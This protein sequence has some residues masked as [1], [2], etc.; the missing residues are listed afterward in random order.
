MTDNLLAPCDGRDGARL[1]DI[2]QV[3]YTILRQVAV[4][5]QEQAVLIAEDRITALLDLLTDK[6]RLLGEL[7]AVQADL[8]PFL[9]IPPEARRWPD[10]QS[11]QIAKYLA[12]QCNE[13][14]A[15]ITM[16]EIADQDALQESRTRLQHQMETFHQAS[17]AH[18]AYD[19]IDAVPHQSLDLGLT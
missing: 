14:L 17:A 19:S 13:M 4:L 9:H 10:S 12:D 6:Q 7:S 5:T 2:L 3:Q 1:L 11:H 15:T 16:Q 18:R 8:A